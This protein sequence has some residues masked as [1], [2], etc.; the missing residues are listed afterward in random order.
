MFLRPILTDASVLNAE[1]L[2]TYIG[3]KQPLSLCKITYKIW[4]KCNHKDWLYWNAIPKYLL[5]LII[6]EKLSAA[7][8]HNWQCPHESS[9]IAI[10]MNNRKC[11]K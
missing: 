11:P 4:K 6:L 9:K 3:L 7:P 8:T 1:K 10:V 2:V 5:P